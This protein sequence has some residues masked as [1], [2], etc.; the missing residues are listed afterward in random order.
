MHENRKAEITGLVLYTMG[1]ISILAV[2]VCWFSMNMKEHKNKAVATAWQVGFGNIS[3]IVATFAFPS[4]YAPRYHLGYFLGLGCL[5]LAGVAS[6]AY[7]VG[8]FIENTG[9]P[10]DRRLLL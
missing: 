7:F 6:L 1:V 9:R 3:G 2:V 4:K 8:C 10:K 5:C